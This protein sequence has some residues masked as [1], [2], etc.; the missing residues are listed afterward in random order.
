LHPLRTHPGTTFLK[1]LAEVR[2]TVMGWSTMKLGLFLRS[3]L[4]LASLESGESE[5]DWASLPIMSAAFFGATASKSIGYMWK[6]GSVTAATVT[7]LSAMDCEQ[8]LHAPLKRLNE[9]LKVLISSNGMDFAR[10]EVSV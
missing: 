2:V 10:D 9:H 5:F 3:A 8:A 6:W 1:L 7:G 4:D